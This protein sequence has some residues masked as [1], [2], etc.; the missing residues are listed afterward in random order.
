MVKQGILQIDV[1][2]GFSDDP[3][4]LPNLIAQSSGMYI[5]WIMHLGWFND[6]FTQLGFEL[7]ATAW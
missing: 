1:T 4:A 5:H 7:S 2:L 3:W 6:A